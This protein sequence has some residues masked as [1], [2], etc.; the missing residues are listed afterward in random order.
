MFGFLSLSLIEKTGSLN[1]V[2]SAKDNNIFVWNG[3]TKDLI[4]HDGLEFRA[5][6]WDRI[7]TNDELGTVQVSTN[8]LIEIANSGQKEEFHIV[9]PPKR[10]KEDAGY[11]T[12]RISHATDQQREAYKAAASGPFWKPSSTTPVKEPTTTTTPKMEEMEKGA[13]VETQPA[14]VEEE[15]EQTEQPDAT[16]TTIESSVE[17][18][19]P[20]EPIKLVIEIMSCRGLI[21][22]DKKGSSDPYVKVHLGS[23]EIHKT[24]HVHKT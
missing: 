19:K 2:Y 20:D 6:D 22:A 3:K 18:P 17:P 7:G 9:P 21:G 8:K 13:A 10:S 24:K 11:I 1:P 12:I 4:D 23:K 16:K 15:K 14:L 5:K